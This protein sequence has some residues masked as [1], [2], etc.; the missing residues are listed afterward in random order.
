MVRGVISRRKVSSNILT[1]RLH[2]AV[3]A[4][5]RM[6][7]H[8]ARMRQLQSIGKVMRQLE[9]AALSRVRAALA[10]GRAVTPRPQP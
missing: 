7:V 8:G 5:Q 4:A 9:S 6:R 1:L 2:E 3:V 10:S